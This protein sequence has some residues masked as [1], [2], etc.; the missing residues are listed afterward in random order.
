MPRPPKDPTTPDKGA[1]TRRTVAPSAGADISAGTTAP[2]SLTDYQQMRDFAATPEPSGDELP[3]QLPRPLFCIQHHQATARHYDFRLEIDGV[4]KSWAVPKGPSYNPKDKRLAMMTE[5]HPLAYATFEGVIPAG[6]YGAGPVLLWDAGAVTFL[7][8]EKT[9]EPDPGVN[10]SR[11]KLVFQLQGVKLQGEWT[12]VKTKGFGGRENSWLLIKHRDATA[13]E[14][15]D[16]VTEEPLSIQSGRDITA[17]RD[18][19]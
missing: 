19:G 12:L 17:I 9:G 3:P 4:L 8:D 16:I 10:L 18:A 1:A 14:D 13:R 6:H 5:D 15:G 7:P 11:G 2:A